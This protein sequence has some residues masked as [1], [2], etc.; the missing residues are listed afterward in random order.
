MRL[1]DTI[2]DDHREIQ[3][4]YD[5]TYNAEDADE[6]TRF[7]NQFTWELARHVVGEELVLYPALEAQ[8]PNADISDDRQRHRAIKEKLGV[9]QSLS[10]SD[11]RFIPTLTILME[12]LLAH[13]HVE[14]TLDLVQLESAIT[15]EESDR[16]ARAFDRAK[17]FAPTRAHPDLPDPPYETV[18]D[19]VAA[20]L[21]HLWDLFRRW[22]GD[23]L[24]PIPEMD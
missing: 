7:Q 5:L 8:L 1:T 10:C 17:W 20:P 6:Q 16:L 23:G 15:A 21:D 19:F 2:R 9:F 22:P 3:S 12:E 24:T 11:P 13:I 14:E 18:A 4:Y